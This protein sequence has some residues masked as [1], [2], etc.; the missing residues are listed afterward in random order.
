M[1]KLIISIFILAL[2]TQLS[3]AQS[4]N[5]AAYSDKGTH[6]VAA[7][8]GLDYGVSLSV[9]YSYYLPAFTPMM[10]MA[11][12]QVPM[13]KELF[14]DHKVRLGLQA[15]LAEVDNFRFLVK[16]NL[17]AKRL[18][19]VYTSQY[20][21]GNEI[22]LIAGYYRSKWYAGAEFTYDNTSITHISHSEKY[23]NDYPGAENGWYK[24][25]AGN[26]YYGIQGGY[27]FKSID[28]SLRMG[29]TKN[30]EFKNNTLPFYTT[31]GVNFR[32]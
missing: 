12:F 14:D 8:V 15:Q 22:G 27:S 1:K 10:F 6:N 23:K 32:F 5:W 19:N 20:S 30:K 13:G 16:Y 31:L 17:T 18:Q 26:F 24:N 21:F 25:F 2:Y 9:R 11:D 28:L 7:E 3:M 4:Y 29:Q